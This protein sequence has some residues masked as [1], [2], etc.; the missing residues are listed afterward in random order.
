MACDFTQ[1]RPATFISVVVTVIGAL[2][3]FDMVAI[4][5]EGGPAMALLMFLH[6]ICMRQLFQSMDLDLDMVLQ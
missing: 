5:T 2:R 4:M 1:L 3:S 6:I